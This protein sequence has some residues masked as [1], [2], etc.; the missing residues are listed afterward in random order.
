VDEFNAPP[1]ERHQREPAAEESADADD[2][3]VERSDAVG[4]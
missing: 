3:S 1:V 2:L 4:L